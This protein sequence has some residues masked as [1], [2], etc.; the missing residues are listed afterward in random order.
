MDARRAEEVFA[1]FFGGEGGGDPFTSM[2]GGAGG[3]MRGFARGDGMGPGVRMGGMPGG[4]PMMFGGFGPG[5][6]MNGMNGMQGMQGMHGMPGG[7]GMGGVPFEASRMA[8]A[9]F[10][11]LK[12]GTQVTIHGLVKCCRSLETPSS[13]A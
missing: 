7:R 4:V 10:D 9:R 12:P 13:R 6:S 3:D 11:V 5:M 1:Q 8:P 2:F